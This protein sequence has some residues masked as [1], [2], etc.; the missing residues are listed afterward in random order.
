MVWLPCLL[1][2]GFRWFAGFRGLLLQQ[3]TL[4]K[5]V[6]ERG[7]DLPKKT[8]VRKRFGEDPWGQ[9]IPKRW[10]AVT[11]RG[12]TLQERGEEMI[13]SEVGEPTGLG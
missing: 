13:R 4:K 10:K 1:C 12:V 8:D 2:L 6:G 3:D 9:P 5:V 7:Y 11:L